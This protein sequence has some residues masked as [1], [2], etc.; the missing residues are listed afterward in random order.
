M[1]GPLDAA[2]LS[3]G[4][5]LLVGDDCNGNGGNRRGV[6]RMERSEIRGGIDALRQSRITL[7]SIRATELKIATMKTE[8]V[9]TRHKSDHDDPYCGLRIFVAENTP[10]RTALGVDVI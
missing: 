2:G 10:R 6:A 1:A 8:D 3:F 5:D 4:S 7:R 9:D